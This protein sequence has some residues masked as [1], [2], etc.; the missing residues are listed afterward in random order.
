VHGIT[1]LSD[2]IDRLQRFQA[3]GADV[4]F[5]PGVTQLDQLADIVSAVDRPLNVLVRPGSPSVEELAELGIKRISVGGALAFAAY[6]AVFEA[7]C[8]L[9][10]QGTVGYLDSA[11]AGVS[12]TR[13]AFGA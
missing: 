6:A 1:D 12:A 7:A 4:L 11:A 10:D 2:T 13:A 8:E 3:A 5:A 9:R